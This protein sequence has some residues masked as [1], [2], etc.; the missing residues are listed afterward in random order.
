MLPAVIT[1]LLIGILLGI[2]L[3]VMSEVQTEIATEFTGEDNNVNLT[4]ATNNQTTLTN[5]SLPGY[6]LLSETVVNETGDE[7]PDTEYNASKD[8]VITWSDD[9]VAGSTAYYTENDTVNITSTFIYEPAD[10]PEESV[11]NVSEGLG[12]FSGWIPVIVVVIAA[13]IVLGIV[14]RRFGQTTQA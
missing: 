11:A 3:Y 2:G 1:I 5:A 12:D 14:L 13:A 10:S 8:G 4:T 7:I 6:E 9:L